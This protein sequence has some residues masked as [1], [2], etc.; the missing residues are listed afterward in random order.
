MEDFNLNGNQIEARLMLSW[1]NAEANIW[2]QDFDDQQVDL[3]VK[4]QLEL[5]ELGIEWR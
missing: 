1:F 2:S 3:V 5:Q 4:L